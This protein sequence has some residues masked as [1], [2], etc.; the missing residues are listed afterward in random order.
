[1]RPSKTAN[2]NSGFRNGFLIALPF[3]T[4]NQPIVASQFSH[5]K[6]SFSLVGRFDPF[7]PQNLWVPDW[8]Q[9]H[10]IV[11]WQK[12]GNIKLLRLQKT[13]FSPFQPAVAG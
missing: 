10:E 6:P 9:A 1:M 4:R 12:N 13:A 3:F 11:P 2:R 8:A 7:L 5:R